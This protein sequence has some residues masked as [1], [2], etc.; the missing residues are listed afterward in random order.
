MSNKI[1]TDNKF[2]ILSVFSFALLLACFGIVLDSNIG[3]LK[4]A[5]KINRLQRDFNW[6]SDIQGGNIKY[7]R[8]KFEIYANEKQPM[9]IQ[10]EK[11]KAKYKI[12]GLVE[13]DLDGSLDLH[14]HIGK[15][16]GTPGDIIEQHIRFQISKEKDSI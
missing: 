3:Y 4:N 6:H 7:L 14:C 12:P 13:V 10:C 1:S 8:K 9:R 11:V 16:Q 15:Y 2:K 5:K